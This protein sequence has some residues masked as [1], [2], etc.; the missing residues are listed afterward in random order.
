MDPGKLLRQPGFIKT[1]NQTLQSD[2]RLSGLGDKTYQNIYRKHFLIG[3]VFW[4]VRCYLQRST[5]EDM[6][7]QL[8]N[9]IILNSVCI[10]LLTA[11]IPS[12]WSCSYF[13]KC[14]HVSMV[15]WSDSNPDQSRG[16]PEVS[17]TGP[18]VY[19]FFFLLFFFFP[20]SLCFNCI[21]NTGGFIHRPPRERQYLDC[22]VEHEA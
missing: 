16:N 10:T 22:F 2:R 3:Q 20:V 6:N 9:E 4:I 8:G 5:H 1:V 7:F 13:S 17:A 21:W 12:I 15:D 14:Q 11:G 18:G 19:T